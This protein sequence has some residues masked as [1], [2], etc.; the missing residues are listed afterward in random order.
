MF[1]HFLSRMKL[2]RDVY[3]DKESG[4]ITL[5]DQS[6]HLVGAMS[7]AAQREGSLSYR[8]KMVVTC[9]KGM[10]DGWRLYLSALAIVRSLGGTLSADDESVTGYSV[11]IWEK[12]WLSSDLVRVPLDISDQNLEYHDE[13]FNE[14]AK[15]NPNISEQEMEEFGTYDNFNFQELFRVGKLNPH[16]YNYGFSLPEDMTTKMLSNITFKKISEKDVL[17]VNALWNDRF[18]KPNNTK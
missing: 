5:Y 1:S 14:L 18:V 11:D 9:F 2:K 15:T 17:S 6:G 16:I 4:F 8:V 12:I 3:F 10:G 7:I 13:Y